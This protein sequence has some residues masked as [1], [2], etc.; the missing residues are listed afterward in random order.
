MTPLSAGSRGVGMAGSDD[1][2][3]DLEFDRVTRP[4][5][6]DQPGGQSQTGQGMSYR[7]SLREGVVGQADRQR[8]VQAAVVAGMQVGE[9]AEIGHDERLAGPP[10]TAATQNEGPGPGHR[11]RAGRRRDTIE[12]HDPVEQRLLQLGGSVLRLLL[13]RGGDTDLWR[14]AATLRQPAIGQDRP[15]RLPTRGTQHPGGPPPENPPRPQPP[16]PP[17]PGARGAL[18]ATP[19]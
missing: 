6:H 5:D 17:R 12:L 10:G 16:G 7:P 1:R 18:M 14:V 13:L 15:A 19:G 9:L 8:E 4:E 11:H 3:D 2:G